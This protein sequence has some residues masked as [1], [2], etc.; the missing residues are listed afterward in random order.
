MVQ[1]LICFTKDILLHIILDATI[2]S[3]KT[4]DN[5]KEGLSDITDINVNDIYAKKLEELEQINLDRDYKKLLQVCNLKKEITKNIA[6]KE[7][8]SDYEEKAKQQIMI[9]EG[10]QRYLKSTYFSFLKNE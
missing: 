7:L 6:N 8:D 3:V 4:L 10:L 2:N 1:E 5:I 9:N